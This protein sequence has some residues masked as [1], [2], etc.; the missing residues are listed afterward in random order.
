MTTAAHS[1]AG[2]GQAPRFGMGWVTWRQHRASLAGACGLLGVVIGYML[3]TGL[4]MR[5]ALSNL[6]ERLASRPLLRQIRQR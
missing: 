1:P 5:S 2:L 4:Q 3:V 6:G